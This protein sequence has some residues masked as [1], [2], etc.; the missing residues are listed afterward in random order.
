[1]TSTAAIL[2]NFDSTEAPVRV[3]KTVSEKEIRAEETRKFTVRFIGLVVA[4]A[5][6]A[7]YTVYSNMLLTKTKA[8][9][10]KN[11]EILTELQS[12]NVYLD[13]KIESMVS[14]RNAEEYAANE[15]GLIKFSGA[16]IVYVNIEDENVIVEHGGDTD[17]RNQITTFL[18]T[19]IDMAG[20]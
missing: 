1:M 9:I 5:F 18:D 7:V 12:E 16:Q 17:F 4:V 19:V 10:T 14:V 11:T 6:L 13:Y 15:I 20:N 3:R 8:E 2:A